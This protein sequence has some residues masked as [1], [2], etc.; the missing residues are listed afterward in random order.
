MNFEKEYN[1]I[2]LLHDQLVQEVE[3]KNKQLTALKT[4]YQKLAARLPEFEEMKVSHEGI[5]L[6]NQDL[7]KDNH[8]K[9][10][11][12]S[13]LQMKLVISMAEIERLRTPVMVR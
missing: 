1:I 3:A 13:A 7:Q 10:A 5:R 8:S 11:Y 9:A 6:Q 12:I 2:K 4:E